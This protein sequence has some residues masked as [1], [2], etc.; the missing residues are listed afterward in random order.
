MEGKLFVFNT[1]PWRKLS[2][3]RVGNS[4]RCLILIGGQADGFFS[5]SYTEALTQQLVDGGWSVVQAMFTSWYAGYGSATLENDNEDLDQ[6][7]HHLVTK[8]GMTEIALLGY[9]TG[10]QDVLFYLQNGQYASKVTHVV[11]HG[12]LRDPKRWKDVDPIA[13][14]FYRDAAQRM[15]DE[16]RGNQLMPAEM[17]P[18]PISAFRFLALGGLQGVE[19]FFN[20]T[21]KEEEMVNIIGH[22]KVPTL[23]MFA[24]TDDYRPL[25]ADRTQLLDK[26]QTCIDADVSCKW[27]QGAADEHLNFLKGYEQEYTSYIVTFLQDEER[28]KLEKEEEQRREI[29]AEAKRGRSI[30]FQKAGLKRS[31]SQSSVS[32]QISIGSA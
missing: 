1:N 14:Q 13:Q 7:V 17:H 26:I 19:D 24:C 31:I 32:S 15:V 28:K 20:P 16:G 23:I 10:A 18:L 4:R 30:V 2:A 27:L 9:H 22:I 12:G 3:F 25:H 5:L 6:L 21:L 11:F 29:E 8:D